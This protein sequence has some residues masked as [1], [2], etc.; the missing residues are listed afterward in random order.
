MGQNNVH[1][2][3]MI[4]GL[5]IS[6]L[7]GNNVLS[8]PPIFSQESLPI[9]GNDIV[10]T[11]DIYKWPHLREIPLQLIDDDHIGLLIDI[12]VPKAM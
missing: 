4:T 2:G 6:D 3:F 8:L 12:I 5:E 11:L 10:A 7:Y 1:D 9:T